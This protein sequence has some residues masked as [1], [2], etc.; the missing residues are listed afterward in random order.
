MKRG[1]LERGLR[2]RGMSAGG[3][4][5]V[6]FGLLLFIGLLALISGF[7]F[8]RNFGAAL[9]MAR[10]EVQPVGER[11][12]HSIDNGSFQ[13][14][15]GYLTE[16]AKT[17]WPPEKFGPWVAEVSEK[18]GKLKEIAVDAAP[19]AEV[20]MKAQGSDIDS[21][22]MHFPCEYEKGTA[23]FRLVFAKEDA[24]WRISELDKTLQPA[25]ETG[26]EEKSAQP[27]AKAD[28]PPEPPTKADQPAEAHEDKAE[29]APAP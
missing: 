16:S 21:L 25:T 7:F 18:L 2:R 13:A 28:P 29:P 9:I 3:C 12:I 19:T 4:F 10:D 23:T 20:I 24:G 27:E 17:N 14:A 26:A 11:F 1:D 5:L 22:P 15:F 8:Y 6:V